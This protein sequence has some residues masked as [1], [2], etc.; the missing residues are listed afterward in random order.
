[1][2][3]RNFEIAITDFGGWVSEYLARGEPTCEVA[4]FLPRTLDG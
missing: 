1:M 3:D 2:N 4:M